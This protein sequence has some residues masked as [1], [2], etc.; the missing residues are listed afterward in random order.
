MTMS[1]V[2]VNTAF[3]QS[4]IFIAYNTFLQQYTDYSSTLVP[5][6][7]SSTS[8]LRIT[9][10][11]D[12]LSNDANAASSALN[13][14]FDQAV[15]TLFTAPTGGQLAINT[16]NA[17]GLTD[18]VFIGVPGTANIDGTA[19]KVLQFSSSDNASVGTLYVYMPLFSDNQTNAPDSSLYQSVPAPSWITSGQTCGH[20]VF[21]NAGVFAD[22]GQQ[23]G[24]TITQQTILGNIEDQLVTAL[25][26]GCA[27]LPL[28]STYS[29]NTE[30][31]QDP[32]QHYPAGQTANA[33]GEFMHTYQS[34]GNT[35]FYGAKNPPQSLTYG[36]AYAIAYDD[37]GNLSTTMTVVNDI[38]SPRVTLSAWNS[39]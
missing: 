25:N 17:G 21:A 39:Q 5:V 26:R 10:P 36:L 28:A 9:N 13:W 33:Y 30:M 37:Q 1:E 27:L 7:D 18:A 12:I 29:D 19:Y 3:T 11:S 23:T 8:Y 15:S 6:P 24:L 20:M 16:G 32:S 31:W 22:S 34:A 38:T 4:S 2:G 35:I 14:A